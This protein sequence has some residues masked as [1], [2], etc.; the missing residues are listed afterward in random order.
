MDSTCATFDTTLVYQD[1]N[2]HNKVGFTRKVSRDFL[3]A[4]SLEVGEAHRLHNNL[5][6]K[7]V[8]LGDER[9]EWMG[10]YV[11]II[12]EHEMKT[13]KNECNEWI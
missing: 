9:G 7:L 3:L 5:Q 11:F 2:S 12:Y 1:P 4:L 13:V 6:N 10:N 8:P